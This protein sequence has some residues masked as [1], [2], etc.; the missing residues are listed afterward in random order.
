MNNI[1]I[2]ARAPMGVEVIR[3]KIVSLG[4]HHQWTRRQVDTFFRV[5]SG[6]LKLRQEYTE[7]GEKAEL[8]PYL[9]PDTPGPRASDYL[10]IPIDKSGT[11]ERLLAE[12]LGITGQVIK[13]RELWLLDNHTVRVHLDTVEGLGEFCEIEA[14]VKDDGRDEIDTCFNEQ[15]KRTHTLLDLLGIAKQDLIG[16]AYIDLLQ[17]S[18]ESFK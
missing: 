6:R 17:S 18:R 1:E 8:I 4:G 16:Q 3:R 2:K 12:M 15:T 7:E 14:L 5:T 10:V 13:N 9:R 11:L